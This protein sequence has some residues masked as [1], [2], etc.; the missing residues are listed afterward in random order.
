MIHIHINRP[1]HHFI[2]QIRR[3]GHQRWE[4]VTGKCKT[5]QAAMCKAINAMAADHNRARV[6]LI[7]DCGYYEPTVVLEARK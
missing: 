4:T 6:L 1:A 7:A 5:H 2:G 3:Y